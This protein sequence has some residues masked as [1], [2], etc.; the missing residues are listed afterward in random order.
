MTRRTRI[1]YQRCPTD[2]PNQN[3]ALSIVIVISAIVGIMIDTSIGIIIVIEIDIKID[4]YLRLC[5]GTLFRIVE[6]FE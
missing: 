3:H 2:N 1:R 4:F 5:L 6:E